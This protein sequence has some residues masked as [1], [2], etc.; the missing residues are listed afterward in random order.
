MEILE[1]QF[2]IS[3]MPDYVDSKYNNFHSLFHMASP[4]KYCGMEVAENTIY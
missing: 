1:D 4:F 2:V 3:K